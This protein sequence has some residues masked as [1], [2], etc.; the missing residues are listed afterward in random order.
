MD[1]MVSTMHANARTTPHIRREIQMASLG[2]QRRFGA[3]IRY[4][5]IHRHAVSK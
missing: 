2:E 1:A 4:S 5:P 3:P